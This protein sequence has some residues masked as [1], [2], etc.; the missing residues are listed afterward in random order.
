MPA[1]LPGATLAQNQANPSQGRAVTMDP[2]SG[3]KG[4]PLDRDQ[5]GNCS[6]G[7]LSTGIGFGPGSV[8]GPTA[9]ASLLAAGF[10]DDQIPG[11][12]APSYGTQNAFLS[13]FMYV[14]GGR[15]VANT[16]PVTKFSIPFV[17]SEYTAGIVIGAAG[18][19]GSRDGG[20]GPA[21]T[22]FP[23]KMVTAAADV[24]AG[25]VIETGFVNRS[26]VGLKTGQSAHGSASAAAAAPA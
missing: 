2:L 7:G 25:A 26:G 14:G 18:N 22:P 12:R 11:T 23:M 10:N 8:F 24:A 20:A 9:P 19:G 16:D 6:T 17:P 1:S 4:S 5:A 13:R 21:F 3:P 15:M